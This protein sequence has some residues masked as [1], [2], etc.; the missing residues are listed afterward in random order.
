MQ[1]DHCNTGISDSLNWFC[2]ITS[3]AFV[4]WY[5]R[6]KVLEKLVCECSGVLFHLVDSEWCGMPISSF[7]LVNYSAKITEIEI[8]NG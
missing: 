4:H 6:D 3:H 7:L 8:S 5:K 2:D 1:T